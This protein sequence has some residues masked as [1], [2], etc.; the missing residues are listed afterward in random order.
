METLAIPSILRPGM[1]IAVVDTDKYFD[2]PQARE[3]MAMARARQIPVRVLIRQGIKLPDGFLRGLTDVRV[4]HY[5]D[6]GEFHE[7]AETINEEITEAQ[8]GLGSAGMG[9]GN[10]AGAGDPGGRGLR[11]GGTPR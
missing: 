9:A 10:L 4:L 8:H 7:Q 1:L 6:T 2:H 11:D 3:H 5:A